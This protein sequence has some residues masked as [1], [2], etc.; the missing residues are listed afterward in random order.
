VGTIFEVL[1]GYKEQQTIQR[2]TYPVRV[3]VSVRVGVLVITI[4]TG[5]DAKGS[6]ADV[7]DAEEAGE[8]LR[9]RGLV[10]R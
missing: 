1:E 5:S 4:V 2:E 3:R 9:E 6:D 10:F 8:V 7:E